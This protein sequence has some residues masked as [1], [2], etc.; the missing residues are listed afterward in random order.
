MDNLEKLVLDKIDNMRSEIIKFHQQIVRIPSENPP[1]KYK[2]VAK[3]TEDKMKEIGLTTQIKRNNVIGEFNKG[4][5]RI[6]I[7]NGH[8]DTVETFNG[9]TKDPFGGEILD[10]KIYGRGSSDDKSCVTAEI[11]ALKALIDSGVD[12]KGTVIVTAVGDEETGGLR[13]TEYLL[14]SGLVDGD[15][16]LLGDAPCDYPIGYT[17]GTMYITFT[18]NGK[19]AHGL[20][21]PDMPEPYRNEYSGINT[22]E[23]MLK[24]MNFLME[25]KKEFLT[26]ETKYPLPDGYTNKVSSVNLAEIHGGNKIT[27]VPKKCYLHCSINIIPEQSVE[28][29]KKRIYDYIEQLKQEDPNLDITVQIPISMEPF[30]I[31]GKSDFAIAVSKAA[32][33]IFGEERQF[34]LFMPS[35]DAHWFQERGIE[36]VLIGTTKMDNRVHAEDEFVYIEDLINTTKLY[37]LT[38]M[39]YLR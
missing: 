10:G 15:V 19:Q 9:W 30:V 24:I 4:D 27:T 37:A 29:I 3:F 34:K 35:T 14:S 33:T 12:L 7:F 20:G 6:L 25:L 22:I 2:E 8:Y 39:N 23:R 16:C 11:F 18:I 28:G 36:T 31:D 13:G 32:K 26:R 38:A 17:G 1:S 5:G 21:G